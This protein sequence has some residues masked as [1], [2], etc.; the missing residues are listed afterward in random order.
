MIT[1]E[2]TRYRPY[3]Q[4]IHLFIFV[5]R[6][7]VRYFELYTILSLANMPCECVRSCVWA[8]SLHYPVWAAVLAHLC[9]TMPHVPAVTLN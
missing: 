1:R 4:S 2:D 9:G 8:L 5:L 3:S 7:D 6:F